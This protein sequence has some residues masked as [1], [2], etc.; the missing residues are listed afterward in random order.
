MYNMSAADVAIQKKATSFADELIPYEEYAE[1]HDGNLPEEVDATMR[2]RVLELGL[3]STNMPI[4][5][6]GQGCTMF[7]QVLVQEQ[8]GRVTNALAW[9]M[10]TPPAWLAKVATDE[11]IERYIKPAIRGEKEE[12]YAI[13]EEFAGSDVDAITST[14]RRCGDEYVLNGV[15]WHVTSF[16]S[17]S[18]VFFQG[19]LTEGVN[20][21]EHAMFI[22][23]LPHPGVVVDRTPAYTHTINH[24]H[25]I[26]SFHDVRVPASAMVGDEGDG[27]GF[28]YEW[29][30]FERMMVSAR[31]L[32]GAQRLVDETTAFAKERVVNG[33]PITEFGAVSMMLANSLTELFAARSMVYETAKNIDA[34]ADIKIQHTQCS[35]AKLFASEMAGRVADRCVQIYAGRGYMR[36]NVAERL[37]RE[38]RV[39]RIWEGTSEVQ[40]SIIADQMVKRGPAMFA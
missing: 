5:L 15:K 16:N 13:T 24:H 23:D 1:F 4:A 18:F 37:F 12:A 39:E 26:V 2:A 7:Q 19:K 22:I 35:M 27:M 33:R 40:Q 29:F 9:I 3:H 32:G 31:C 30:R 6:G 11:Q 8:T 34:A 20:A 36:E 28:A 21:G 10:A 14:A 25:P 17:A 38:L